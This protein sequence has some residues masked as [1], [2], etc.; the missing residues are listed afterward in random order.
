MGA[1]PRTGQGRQDPR[2]REDSPSPQSMGKQSSKMQKVAE[3]AT[4]E[5]SAKV[6]LVTKRARRNRDTAPASEGERAA[7]TGVVGTGKP[8]AGPAG[9]AAAVAAATQAA[10]SSAGATSEQLAKAGAR[11]GVFAGTTAAA[12]TQACVGGWAGMTAKVGSQ[13]AG[14]AATPAPRT[15]IPEI[16]TINLSA[17]YKTTWG[18]NHK[19]HILGRGTYGVVSLAMR[20]SDGRLVARKRFRSFRIDDE[21]SVQNEMPDE[22][23][24]VNILRCLANG[25]QRQP[26][27]KHLY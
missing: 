16:S 10:A 26:R 7:A 3:E 24:G 20:L 27:G 1:R 5:N 12:G 17:Q 6:H 2:E 15:D 21:W 9:V 4:E 19:E 8:E 22:G 14:R 18:G 13:G 11:A 23:P 25:D